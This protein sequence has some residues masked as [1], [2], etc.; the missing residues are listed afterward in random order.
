MHFDHQGIRL[1]Y[2]DQG[3]GLPLVFLHAFPVNRTMWRDQIT[4][5]SS[6]FRTIAIDLRGHGESDA[7]LWSYSLDDYADDVRALLDRLQIPQAVLIG[8]SMGGYVGFAFCR[9]Y[10]QRVKG[11]VLCDTRAQA[12]SPEGR[13]GRFNLA[14]AASKQGAAAVADMM[15]PKLLG[16][17]SIQTRSEVVERVRRMVLSNPVNGI[18]VDLMAM[19]A[20]PDSTP[21]LGTI[22]SPTLV[23]IGDEDHTTPLADA[24]L[25]AERI[26]GAKLAIIPGAGHL[27]NV[28]Q[29]T[30]FNRVLR[31]FLQSLAG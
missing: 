14:Q 20:R 2:E 12:D 21:L 31:E 15:V 25:M 9:K 18:V 11:L 6:Q 19:A 5:L 16:A 10:P 4:D 27:S 30:T 13:A 1:G 26:P 17:T 29:P 8:L 24:T 22:A 23:I 7:P 28:E 3:A